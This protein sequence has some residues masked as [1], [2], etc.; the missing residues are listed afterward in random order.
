VRVR[1][2][3]TELTCAGIGCNIVPR[4]AA[5]MSVIAMLHACHTKKLS[6]GFDGRRSRVVRENGWNRGVTDVGD[7][8]C[9]I[10]AGTEQRSRHETAVNKGTVA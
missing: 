6:E 4:A 3:G 8:F 1:T 7:K 9:I 5:E 10:D 2:S